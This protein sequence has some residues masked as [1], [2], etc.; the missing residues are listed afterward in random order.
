MNFKKLVLVLSLIIISCSQSQNNNQTI[1]TPQKRGDIIS[2]SKLESYSSNEIKKVLISE[3]YTIPIL[4]HLSYTV[5]F[6]KITYLTIDKNG[7]LTEASGTILIPATE[8][9][10]PLLSIQHGVEF[11]R[12]NV[13][14]VKGAAIGEG[15]VGLITASLGFT[16]TIPDYLGYGASKLMHP[17]IHANLTATTTIDLLRAAKTLLKS[18]STNLNE[19]L[20]LYGYS[21]GGYAT[22]AT[23]KEIEQHYADEFGIT[24]VAPAAGPY[25][26]LS[27]VQQEFEVQNYPYMP[28]IAFLFTAYNEYYGWNNLDN[29]FKTPYAAKMSSLFSGNWSTQEIENQLPTNFKELMN[30]TFVQDLLHGNTPEVLQAFQENTLLDWAPK[31]PI[32]FYHGDKDLIVP[33]HNAVTAYNN[34]KASGAQQVEIVTLENKTHATANV[35]A[36]LQAIDWFNELKK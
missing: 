19:Q 21:E 9:E 31:A 25:D 2:I 17:Y 16:T 30:P 7:A 11:H 3:G 5:A 22:L 15:L 1:P 36:V 20:F 13:T 26:I 18:S 34:L 24:A 32:R 35:P 10:T 27:S 28:N 14:S 12:N 4:E 23:Q 8:T 33:Y 29:I 6:H